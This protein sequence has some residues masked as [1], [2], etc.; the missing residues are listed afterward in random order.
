M[1][2]HENIY[3]KRYHLLKNNIFDVKSPNFNFGSIVIEILL[4]FIK[5]TNR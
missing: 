3:F 5:C 4:Y 2:D 1:D